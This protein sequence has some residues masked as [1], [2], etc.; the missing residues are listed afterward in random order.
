M[1]DEMKLIRD[2]K[3]RPLEIIGFWLDITERRQ[4]MEAL[5]QSEESHRMV[6]ETTGQLIYDYDVPSG[7]ILWAGAIE[8]MTGYQP[9]EF[10]H[11]DIKIWEEMIH[12]EDRA[13]A[14]SQLDDALKAASPYHVMYRFRCKDGTYVDI[15]DTGAFL[16][17]DRGKAYRMLGAMKEITERK[18]SESKLRESEEKYRSFFEN[19]LTGDYITTIDGRILACNPSFARIFGFNTVEEALHARAEDLYKSPEQRKDFLQTL[20]ERKK[21]EYYEMEMRRLNG[22]PVYIVENTIGKF[23]EHGDLIGIQGYIFDDTKRK[24]LED[25]VIQVQKMDSIGTMAG[26]IAHDFNNILGII[27]GY[28]SMLDMVRE[29]REKF[30]QYVNHINKATV[31]GAALVKQI[32]T[33]ARKTEVSLTPVS[34]NGAIKE[35]VKML[36][37]TFPKTITIMTSLEKSLPLIMIDRTSLNQALLNLC[38]N[39]RDAMPNGGSLSLSTKLVDGNKLAE[40]FSKAG[41]NMYI[42]VSVADTGIGMDES[43]RAKIFEPFFTTKEIGRG[44]G[45][46]LS[47]VYGIVEAHRG[48]VGVESAPGSGT[49]ITLYFPIPGGIMSSEEAVAVDIKDIAGGKETILIVEDEEA[50]LEI[51]ST[52]LESKGYTVLKAR[53]GL[54]CVEVYEHRKEGID[55]ILSDTGLPG[56]SGADAFLKI[57]SI[58]PGVKMILASG[59]FDPDQKAELRKA[60]VTRFIQKPYKHQDI[61]KEVRSVLDER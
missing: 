23:D 33:F 9:D 21:L 27:G 51:L 31:R 11:V 36:E 26:G 61:L 49:A 48:F 6:V 8:A 17:D 18:Q 38:V 47:V 45:L 40:R 42:A 43:T 46:G 35:L 30:L 20:R 15:E 24:K 60:G 3:G 37:E 55:L 19:D 14:I 56:M 34:V 54:E 2:D 44:T 39:S 4:A 5:Q 22:Q 28:S 25:H 10:A 29:N 7:R 57:A 53:N 59:F 58:D 52:L 1:R 32:L 50:L 41:A 12:P 16:K 13:V